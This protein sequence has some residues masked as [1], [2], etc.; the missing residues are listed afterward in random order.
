[1]LSTGTGDL[2][3]AERSQHRA[4]PL[5]PAED[6]HRHLGDDSQHPLAA[7]QQPEP[8]IAR[9]IQMRP[10]DIDDVALDGDHPQPQQIVGSNPVAQAVRATGV[11]VD[12][13]ADHAG[14]LARRIRCV[15]ESTLLHCLGDADIGDPGLHHRAAIGIVD[16]EDL[17][18]PHEPDHHGV[19][20][21]QRPAGQAGAR[22]ARHHAHPLA[23]AQR[24]HRRHLIGGLRQHDGKRGLAIGGQTVGFVGFEP[25]RLGDHAGL[26]Q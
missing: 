3:G 19:R 26:R 21:R 16:I 8:V 23:M 6:A 22:P 17:V 11:H 7:G 10:A 1:M 13:A 18:H 9:G 24:Q 20:H 2:V 15:E 25:Q 14:E 5:W 12:V 4:R